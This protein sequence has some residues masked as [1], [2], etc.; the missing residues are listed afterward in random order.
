MSR[1]YAGSSSISAGE[2]LEP[3]TLA[4]NIVD[5]L[6][7]R[8]AEDILLL[9]IR[10]VASFAD[11]FV[12]ANGNVARQLEAMIEAVE[13]AAP[14]EAATFMGREGDPNSGWILMDYGNVIVHL[15]GPKERGY[16]DLENLWHAAVQVVR[17][18]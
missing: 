17:I 15:F 12:I 5:A 2:Q 7:D 9:D 4:R 14:P 3:D 11:Y 8:Q 6:S 13:E 10:N 18:Q 16:Y 1:P